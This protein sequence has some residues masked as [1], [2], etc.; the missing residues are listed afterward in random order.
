MLKTTRYDEWT[1][2]ALTLHMVSQMLGKA[3][4]T[5]MDPQPEWQHIVLQLTAGGWPLTN[6]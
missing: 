2:T 5:R 1:D 3:K 6:R 4:L